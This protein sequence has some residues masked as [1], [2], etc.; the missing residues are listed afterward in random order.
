MKAQLKADLMLLIVVFCWGFSFL[1]ADIGVGDLGP[2]SLNAWRFLT[3]F[4]VAALISIRRLKKISRAT[5]KYSLILGL[6]LSLLYTS[7]NYG[8]KNTTLANAS[9]LCGLTVIFTPLL[10]SLIYRKAPESKLVFVALMCVCGIALLT[11]TENLTIDFGNLIGDALCIICA[12]VYAVHLLTTEKAV[13]TGDVDAYQ[14][15]VLQLG[16]TG[17]ISLF[18]A[19]TLERFA[20][21]SSPAIWGSVLFLAVICTGLAYIVQTVAQQYTTASHVGVI[22]SFET[23][24]A[25]LVA[26]TIGK[27][28]LTAQSAAGAA[29]IVLGL[30]ILEMD[31]SAFRRKIKA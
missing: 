26:Y 18:M 3:A 28:A 9:F 30:F 6:I 24:F 17:L 23:V 11:L 8:L 1:M 22:N 14:L 4:F 16:V 27:D 25:G 13:R 15:G 2:F 10:S 5:L 29:L 7:M 19:I 21:P 20:L 31:F 12:L